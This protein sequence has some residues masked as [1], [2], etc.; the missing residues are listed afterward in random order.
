MINNEHGEF[1]IE[2]IGGHGKYQII[3]CL[4]LFITG[5][6][7]NLYNTY[8]LFMISPPIVDIV[9]SGIKITTV[10]EY[11]MCSFPFNIN[12]DLSMQTWL[13]EN[14][15]YC[16]KLK[17]SILGASYGL[18]LMLGNTAI[19]LFKKIGAR[20][21]ITIVNCIIAISALFLFIENYYC[22]L[23][24]N[25]LMS[26][27]MTGEKLLKASILTE[28]SDKKY[29]SYFLT[30]T[31]FC[32]AITAIIS[33][34]LFVTSVPWRIVYGGCSFLLLIST[35]IFF[36]YSV[37][38]PRFYLLTNDKRKM[39]RSILYIAKQN[40]VEDINF[41]TDSNHSKSMIS[42][43]EDDD[44]KETNASINIKNTSESKLLI[45][46]SIENDNFDSNNNDNR[47]D[48]E[49]NKK[50][51]NKNIIL[52][53]K[54]S[55][56]TFCFF[57]ILGSTFFEIK[58]YVSYLS[59]N[60]YYMN[61]GVIVAHFLISFSIN[62]SFLGRRYN[63]I[64]C[65]LIIVVLRILKNS[66]SWSYNEFSLLYMG[67][68]ITTCSMIVPLTLLINESLATQDKFKNLSLIYFLASIPSIFGSFLLEYITKSTF[69]YVM[70]GLSCLGMISVFT[71]KDTI[72][73]SIKDR[74]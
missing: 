73:R 47:L 8:F 48:I 71:L 61:V 63:I 59:N 6:F 67:I 54:L 34:A 14:D 51:S 18:G 24:F 35:L 23:V 4:L 21:G 17:T 2:K 26:S 28:F 60:F 30:T 69:D 20:K 10:L 49:F 3:Q 33:F 72:G 53:I 70:I 9:K 65:L 42:I 55:I 57:S 74:W 52:L 62:I 16:D 1:I 37:E 38:N 44:C 12:E 66:L 46:T 58:L 45:R 50:L 22:I 64:I 11:K 31:V 19:N 25:V 29:R 32:S 41:F 36:I 27:G 68:R 39:I 40:K 15:I 56:A 13:I 5:I 43:I 7:V